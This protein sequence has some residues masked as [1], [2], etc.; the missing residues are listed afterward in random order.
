MADYPNGE[1]SPAGPSDDVVPLPFTRLALPSSK[2]KH[3]QAAKVHSMDVLPSYKGALSASL[4]SLPELE[5]YNGRATHSVDVLPSY[6][7]TMSLASLPELEPMGSTDT[8]AHDLHH[9]ATMSLSSLPELEPMAQHSEHYSRSLSRSLGDLPS[10]HTLHSRGQRADYV[11]DADPRSH[12]A[13]Q[14]ENTFQDTQRMTS[15]YTEA[16]YRTQQNTGSFCPPK[17]SHMPKASTWTHLTA[18]T[19][20]EMS[21]APYSRTMDSLMESDRSWTATPMEPA[22]RPYSNGYADANTNYYMQQGQSPLQGQS[23]MRSQQCQQHFRHQPP[24]QAYPEERGYSWGADVTKVR[25]TPPPDQ[26]ELLKLVLHEQLLLDR[27]GLPRNPAVDYGL[28]V[29]GLLDAY[30]GSRY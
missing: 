20:D 22:M 26:R 18:T 23:P 16:Q 8:H 21:W 11:V 13:G 3:A 29:F 5:P 6:Q 12:Y 1:S 14:L 24:R 25:L 17:R 7:N 27:A 2:A 28:Y 15:P 19:L 10:M 30:P 9:K 4:S